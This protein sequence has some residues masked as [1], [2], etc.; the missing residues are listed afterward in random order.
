ME[1]DDGGAPI[2]FAAQTWNERY[3]RLQRLGGPPMP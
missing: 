2:N 3:E 1:P